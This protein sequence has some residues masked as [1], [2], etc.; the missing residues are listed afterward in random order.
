MTGIFTVGD[1]NGDGRPDLLAHA[2]GGKLML[3]RGIGGGRVT[4]AGAVGSGWARRTAKSAVNGVIMGPRPFPGGFGNVDGVPGNDVVAV[5]KTG[6]AYVYGG[7]G[8][9]KF[10]PRSTVATGWKTGDT[11][12][13]LGDFNRD[14]YPDIGRIDEAG[15]FQFYAGKPGGGFAA[16][17]RIGHDWGA[18]TRVIGGFDWD[19][20]RLL[21]V[22]VTTED[23]LMLLYRGNGRG[24]WMSGGGAQ[25]SHGWTIAE[26]VFHAGDFDGDGR[27]ELIA[28]MKDGTLR[29]YPMTGKGSFAAASQIGH[30]WD[31]F[32]TVFSPG[33]FNGD[34]KSD[35]IAVD[36]A[37]VMYLYPG[38]GAGK[39]LARVKIGSGWSVMSSIG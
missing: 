5:A 26:E 23:G 6:E 16:P 30:A 25:I 34:G 28:R 35:I 8:A 2:N 24:G 31:V 17:V 3:Y 33:D 29:T 18:F 38:T 12:I 4:G 32:E 22:V 20:D 7:N 27:G 9:G 13:P 19:G 21:D 1:F 14:G 15:L 39:M 36:P 11:V 37:G 10:G